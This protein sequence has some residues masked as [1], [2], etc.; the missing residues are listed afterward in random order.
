MI[1][2]ATGLPHVGDPCARCLLVD[3]VARATREDPRVVEGQ[4]LSDEARWAMDAG[5]GLPLREWMK[6]EGAWR[7]RVDEQRALFSEV[8]AEKMRER[9]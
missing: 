5:K 3:D 2:L 7:L 9:T 4:K 6:L 1:C 8:W